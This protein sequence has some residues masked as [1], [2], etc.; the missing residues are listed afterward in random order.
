MGP[1]LGERWE[2]ALLYA[3]RVHALQERKGS[4][5]PYVSHLL[6]V[7]ALVLEAG[8]DED[9]AIAALLHDAAEDQG[10]EPRLADIER[11]FGPRVAAIV[12][13][14]S[15]TTETPKPPWRERKEAYIAHLPAL[16]EALPQALL[17]S[18]ADKLHNARTILADY[19]AVGERLF[20]RFTGAR[21]GTLWY[22]GALVRAY[23]ALALDDSLLDE[24]ERTVTDLHTLA[25][26]AGPATISAQETR[27]RRGGQRTQRTE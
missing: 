5:V 17:V 8:G 13:A 1:V 9:Q 18:L 6:S 11:R 10:G 23:R 4:G 3:S 26:Y 22:Y 21:D 16:R 12:R 14:C 24:L 19:R 15:D 7:A 25:A 27:R 20:D 2:K